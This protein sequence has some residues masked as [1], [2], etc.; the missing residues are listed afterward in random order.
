LLS[1]YNLL[2]NIIDT[3]LNPSKEFI[4]P[5]QDHNNDFRN[6]RWAKTGQKKRGNRGK[7]KR[8]QKHKNESH[9]IPFTWPHLM[10]C[11][12]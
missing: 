2:D 6:T 11:C 9:P 3:V 8:W 12:Y 4:N 10:K 1:L 5:L 7:N